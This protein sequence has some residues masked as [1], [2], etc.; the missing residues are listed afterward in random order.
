MLG[1][2]LGRSQLNCLRWLHRGDRAEL[3]PLARLPPAQG[4][5][6]VWKPTRLELQ[7]FRLESGPFA[8]SEVLSHLSSFE[9]LLMQKTTSMRLLR[10]AALVQGVKDVLGMV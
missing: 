3:E 5:Q 10:L 4:E 2:W 6:T 1:R 8:L 9:Q 7:A